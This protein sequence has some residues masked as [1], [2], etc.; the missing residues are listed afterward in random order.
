[1]GVWV[2]YSKVHESTRVEW[3]AFT[4]DYFVRRG[5]LAN[6]LLLVDASIPPLPL[7][8][9]C[10]NWFGEAQVPFT[11]VF[12]KADK[13]KK[14]VPDAKENIQR[15]REMLSETWNTLPPFFA[16]SAQLK[17]G[18]EPLLKYGSLVWHDG[19]AELAVG[20]IHRAALCVFQGIRSSFFRPRRPFR[21][22]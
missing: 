16:T 1:M 18:R 15:F 14:G 8:I 11:I 22:A 4:R 21:I 6:V 5:T 12:T 13:R 10:A 19:F 9:Y 20:Q 3:N 7:D 17:E 2:S